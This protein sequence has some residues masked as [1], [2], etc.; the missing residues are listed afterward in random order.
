M[1]VLPGYYVLLFGLGGINLGL[2]LPLLAF[3]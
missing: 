3:L 1:R 2:L